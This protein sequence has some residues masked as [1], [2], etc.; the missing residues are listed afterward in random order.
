L[1]AYYCDHFVLPL[2]DQHRF[3]M[4]K[5]A[6]LRA[7]VASELACAEQASP[8]GKQEATEPSW[9]T[10]GVLLVE[11][12]AASDGQLALAHHPRYIQD[13]CAGRLSAAEQRRI[14]FPW[15]LEMVERAR[16]S[17]G[18]TIAAA[19]LAARDGIAF[20]LAG[21]T[22]H[23][24]HAHGEGFC[25]FN[26]VAVTARLLQ[27]EGLG[28]QVLIVDLDVHQGNGSA[29]I[30]AGD[31]SVFTLSIHGARNYPFE[32]AQSS[33]DVDLPDECLD[34]AYLEA[35]QDSLDEVLRQFQPDFLIY[36]AG[37]DVYT[38][39]RLGR[40]N[41]SK[42]GILNRDQMVF[43]FAE[44][45]AL[46]VAVCMGG[47]Y[48]PKIDDIVDIHFNTVRSGLDHWRRLARARSMAQ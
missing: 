23:A 21:G 18:G 45:L 7:R 3:P 36:L 22:H 35:L 44:R 5:Y 34:D 28:R 9:A 12:P 10:R 15:S 20:N 13:F 26:D 19:R 17:A 16:R 11:P 41:L 24:G 37:A 42:Q 31:P 30:L 2:P 46:P 32:K 8:D 38:G 40:L 29:Q 39:D 43:A 6:M 47:G 4:R 14:G 27:T 25:C 1:N 48:C 33:L